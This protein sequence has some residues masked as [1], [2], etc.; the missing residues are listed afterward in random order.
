MIGRAGQW[1]GPRRIESGTVA[2]SPALASRVGRVGARCRLAI[3]LRSITIDLLG[4]CVVDDLPPEVAAW[5]EETTG[6][7]V[8]TVC[9]RSLRA[10]IERL[11]SLLAGAP[12]DVADRLYEAAA[13]RDAGVF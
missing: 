1:D 12:P 5:V 7:V 10:L 6:D 8:S 13:R 9:D 2:A 11:D 3:E 4:A